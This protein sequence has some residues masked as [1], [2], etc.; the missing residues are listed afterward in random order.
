MCLFVFLC[1]YFVEVVGI[2]VSF[3]QF[4]MLFVCVGNVFFFTEIK[5]VIT[6]FGCLVCLFVCVFCLFVCLQLFHF[7]LFPSCK[8]SL[9]FVLIFHYLVRFSCSSIFIGRHFSFFTYFSV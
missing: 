1:V 4:W 9:F 2:S 6:L 3:T 8:N 7:R 5:V